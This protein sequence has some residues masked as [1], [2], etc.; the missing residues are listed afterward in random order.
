M[1]ISVAQI[2]S[3]K[4]DIQENIKKHAFWIERAASEKVKLIAFPE[5]SLTGYEPELANDLALNGGDDRLGEFQDMSDQH[6]IS[7]AIGV[8]TR[9]EA[10]ILISMVIFRPKQA[11]KVYSKQRLHAD[12]LPYFKEGKE[13]VILSLEDRKIAP[14]ICYESLQKDHADHAKKLGADV[15]LASVAKSQKGIEEAYLHY[16]RIAKELSM[17]VLLS[18]SIGYCDNFLSAG[19]S[20]VWNQN[21]DLI[22]KLESDKEGLLVFDTANAVCLTVM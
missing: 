13:Q 5:L 1:K 22:K 11:V 15:Y 21:G 6:Y 9:T 18:N 8:P 3:S 20:A 2:R 10:S 12:E 14:A 16:A 4:G 17:P 7:I 19:Q